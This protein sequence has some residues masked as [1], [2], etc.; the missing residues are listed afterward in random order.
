MST[1]QH[2]KCYLDYSFRTILLKPTILS[3]LLNK[4]EKILREEEERVKWADKFHT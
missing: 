1:V 2:I 4:P 3:T